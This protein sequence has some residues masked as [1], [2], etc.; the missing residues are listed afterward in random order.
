M[1]TKRTISAI[2]LVLS[3]ALVAGCASTTPAEKTVALND[4]VSVDYTGWLDNG[5]IFDTSDESVAKEA[6]IYDELIEYGPYTFMAGAGEVID[7]FDSAVIGMKV[8]ES[9][10]ITLTPDQA[11]G[12]Y[13]PT[14]IQPVNMSVFTQ[15][16]ITPLVNDTLYYGTQ[17]VTVHSIPNNTTVLIDFNHPL[18]GKTLYFKITVR[19]IT[20][21]SAT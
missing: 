10:N 21:A 12:A 4:T 18:A 5:T 11:Y 1:L 16:N 14:L 6:G 17:P 19:S 7:G 2:L 15:Y 13:D 3:I 9:K 8:N 20:A